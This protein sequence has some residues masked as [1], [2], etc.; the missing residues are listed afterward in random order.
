MTELFSVRIETNR[1]DPAL[2]AFVRAETILRFFYP[3]GL[4]SH[5]IARDGEQTALQLKDGLFIFG[6]KLKNGFVLFRVYG[7]GTD[8]VQFSLNNEGLRAINIAGTSEPRDSH[9]TRTTI[10]GCTDYS[11]AREADRKF[12]GLAPAIVNWLGTSIFQD[13]LQPFPQDVASVVNE[14][15]EQIK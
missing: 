14:I 7:H 5:G 1:A 9:L 3:A 10:A 15:A 13:E 11:K 2:E 12:R 8:L 4:V 6:G